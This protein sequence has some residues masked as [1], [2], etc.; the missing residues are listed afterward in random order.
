MTKPKTTRQKRDEELKR[1]KRREAKTRARAV[2]NSKKPPRRRRDKPEHMVWWP[3]TDSGPYVYLP[4]RAEIARDALQPLGTSET[5][6]S[7]G[8]WLYLME[9]HRSHHRN[10]PPGVPVPGLAGDNHIGHPEPLSVCP[11]ALVFLKYWSRSFQDN[12]SRTAAIGPYLG[13][14]LDTKAD[15][16]TTRK[17][18]Y[19]LFAWFLETYDEFLH[20]FELDSLVEESGTRGTLP[21]CDLGFSLGIAY[22]EEAADTGA[23]MA[24]AISALE[25]PVAGAALLANYVAEA[26]DAE[27]TDRQPDPADGSWDAPYW[28]LDAVREALRIG[29]IDGVQPLLRDLEWLMRDC[30]R[31]ADHAGTSRSATVDVQKS[32][33]KFLESMYDPNPIPF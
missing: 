31:L 6:A 17:R 32:A 1:T 16:W 23:N 5:S 28:A 30:I 33:Q 27:F 26:I 13:M 22:L 2:K 18:A 10:Y 4:D 29:G 7:V 11:I 8:Q 19:G 21:G 9:C 20:S 14:L 15:S 3:T 12:R 24:L 25:R